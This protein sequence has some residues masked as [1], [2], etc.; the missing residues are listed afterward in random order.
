M[1]RKNLF[2]VVVLSLLVMTSIYAFTTKKETVVTLEKQKQELLNS[3][4]KENILKRDMLESIL[5]FADEN[6]PIDSLD[7]PSWIFE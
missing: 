7:I 3:I 6:T 2:L 1:K 4:P 5:E